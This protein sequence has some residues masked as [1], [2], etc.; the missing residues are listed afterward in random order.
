MGT[1]NA[2]DGSS[3]PSIDGMD[4]GGVALGGANVGATADTTQRRISTPLKRVASRVPVKDV[5]DQPLLSQAKQLLEDQRTKYRESTRGF[6]WYDWLGWFFPC[7]VWLRS[8]DVRGW[9]LSDVAAGLSVG[10]MVIPQGMSY[11]KL[12]GLPQEYGLYGAFVPCIAYALLGSSRQLAVGPVA[13]TSILLGN[14]LANVFSDRKDQVEE[15]M[16]DPN[17][18]PFPDLQM[19]YNHAAVQVAFVAGC[20][21]TGVGLLRMGW[22]T[23]FLSHAQVSGFMTGAAILIGLSQVKY[24]LGLKIDRSDTIQGNLELIFDNLW[25]FNWREF[26][27][28]MSFIF[29]LLAF[30]WAAGKYKKLTLLKA[31]GPLA[32]CIISIALMNIFKW[33]DDTTDV[34]VKGKPQKAIADIGKIPSGMP[35]FTVGWWVPLYN[36]GKQMSLSALICFIDICESISIAKALAQKNKYQ[37]NA[38]QELRGLGLANLAGAMFQC[39]TTTGSFSRSAVNDSAGAKTPL[40]N[41]VTGLVVM[42]T[43]LVLTP[44]FTHMSA[45]VQGAIIIVGVMGLLDYPEFIYLWKTNKF[46]W[47]VW[48][49]AFLFTIF[50]GV[51][52]GIIVSVCVSLLLV[53]YKTAFPRITTLGKLPGT[54]IYRSTKMYP[55]AELQQGMLMLRVDAPWYFANSSSIG[56]YIRE[57]VA[58][59]RSRAEEVGDHIRFVIIDLS[60]VTDIDSSAMHFLDDFIDELASDGVELVLANPIQQLVLANPI[61]QVLLS[62]KRCG[63]IK[64]I[65]EENVHVNMHDAVSHATQVLRQ[66]QSH[67]VI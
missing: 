48:N 17:K 10:A 42:L 50:L 26:V 3:G 31:L 41:F 30:K 43:L 58:I 56:D 33:Y 23:N 65:R 45:N 63:L 49:V 66:E 54:E 5:M 67:H 18:P 57:K 38:T 40:A 12:A 32:V 53:I 1:A 51:E 24:I 64:K 2:S 61:Q 46:D 22:V 52:V 8:Y 27:M 62:L 6:G 21:Y 39:Y 16:Q 13:V 44:I 34:T 14:G 29:L 60:P 47:V 15:N 7:F 36:V 55:N 19:Q 59:N 25:Q 35:Q 37:L 20:F 11:A 4:S 28:G 9:L